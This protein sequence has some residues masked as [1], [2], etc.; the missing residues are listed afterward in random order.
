M[1]GKSEINQETF[2]Q[3]MDVARRLNY[4]ISIRLNN[5]EET[6][7]MPEEIAR[8]TREGIEI[9]LDADGQSSKSILFA[10]IQDLKMTSLKEKWTQ[11][12]TSQILRDIN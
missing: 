4:G 5:G 1:N 10:N 3:A 7:C 12:N 11:I 6:F 9:L 2:K 8:T